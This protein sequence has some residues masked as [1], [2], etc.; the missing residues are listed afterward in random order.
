MQITEKAY[1]AIKKV[2]GKSPWYEA[3]EGVKTAL[4]QVYWIKILE[5]DSEGY[6]IT[7][8]CIPGQKKAVRQIVARVKKI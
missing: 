4:N 5:E 8:E 3:H 2:I 7:N 6:L 1:E